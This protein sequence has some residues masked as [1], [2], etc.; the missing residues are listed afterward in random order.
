MSTA[1]ISRAEQKIIAEII[2]FRAQFF[3]RKAKEPDDLDAAELTELAARIAG[4]S[5]IVISST[6]GSAKCAHPGCGVRLWAGNTTGVCRA[7][8][9]GDYCG[10][11][12]CTR[13][14]DE[15]AE[16]VG[17]GPR[18]T[19]TLPRAPWEQTAPA[20]EAAE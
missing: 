18:F 3:A 15:Q 9:H 2:R 16:L 19:P 4:A 12:A 8:N 17:A 5:S 13:E 10:C 1:T 14:R 7:H 20:M 11:V 6:R